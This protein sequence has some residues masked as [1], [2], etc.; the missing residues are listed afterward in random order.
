M[1]TLTINL[2]SV[3]AGGDHMTLGL[4]LN[5]QAKRSFN[6]LR[7]EMLAPLTEEEIAAAIKVIV[8]LHAR[9]KTGA[10]VR[11]NLQAG[12]VVTI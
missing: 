12:I 1:T 9:G 11:N 10:Q 4:V 3:C 8:R 7:P 6:V 2:E 5:G